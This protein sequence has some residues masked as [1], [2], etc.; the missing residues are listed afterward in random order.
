MLWNAKAVPI[1]YNIKA[2]KKEVIC[3]QSFVVAV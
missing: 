2:E 3:Y 1:D